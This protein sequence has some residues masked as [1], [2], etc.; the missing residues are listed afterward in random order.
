MTS[1][2]RISLINEFNELT[3][4]STINDSD[5]DDAEIYP[6]SNP[7]V[8]TYNTKGYSPQK[9]FN[10]RF[11]P[12]IIPGKTRPI[13]QL[14]TKGCAGNQRNFGRAPD[15]AIKGNCHGNGAQWHAHFM[16]SEGGKTDGQGRIH[17]MGRQHLRSACQVD[18]SNSNFQHYL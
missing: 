6:L 9:L 11:I 4:Q 12:H 10:N 13:D 8:A 7:K 2:R 15:G 16:D 18:S 1:E 5:G 17:V 3:I 14:I